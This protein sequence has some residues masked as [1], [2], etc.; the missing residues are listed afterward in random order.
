MARS[1]PPHRRSR[2]RIL[3]MDP[4]LPSKSAPN[5]F[6]QPQPA[7]RTNPILTWGVAAFVVLILAGAVLLMTHHAPT[8]AAN[9]VLPLDAHSDSLAFSQIVM[10]EST[11]LSGG[12]STF[13]DGRIRNSGSKV[14]SGAT[15]QVLF[16]SF[17]ETQAPQR[18]T[19]PVTLI[20][21]HQPYVDTEPLSAAPLQPGE[22]RE[23][24]LIFEDISPN[25]NQQLPQIRPVHIT[26]E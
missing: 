26:Y 9:A 11:S 21:T 2:G 18:V 12:K 17:D 3:R 24:R 1:A 20:R 10:S 15:V 4:H 19:T 23:F 7:Q 6:T 8:S 16:G 22:E 13:I 14:V 5:L 25:W